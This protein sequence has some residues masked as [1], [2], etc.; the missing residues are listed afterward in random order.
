[1][2]ACIIDDAE[3]RQ[4]GMVKYS[5]NGCRNDHCAERVETSIS[6]SEARQKTAGSSAQAYQLLDK[7]EKR[8]VRVTV[9]TFAAVLEAYEKGEAGTRT[10]KILKAM[11]G[12]LDALGEHTCISR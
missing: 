5:R 9:I 8:R 10:L 7:M 2:Y 1:M 12:Y 6:K 11:D 4:N 3:G